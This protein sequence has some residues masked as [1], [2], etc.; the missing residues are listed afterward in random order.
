MKKR[1]EYIES[2]FQKVYIKDYSFF[3]SCN[4]IEFYYKESK[5]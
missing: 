4:E 3:A 2:L 5:S 1:M